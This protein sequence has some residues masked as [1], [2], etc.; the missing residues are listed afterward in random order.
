MTMV[1]SV[2]LGII[3]GL[4]EFLPVSSSG[5]LAAASL[6]MGQTDGGL[7]FDLLLHTGTLA[8][9]FIAYRRECVSLVRSLLTLLKK[10]FSHPLHTVPE[11]DEKF[12]VLVF[13]ATLPLV[14]LKWLGIYDAA[15]RVN[16][17][18]PAI[19]ALLMVNGTVLF[20]ADM[21]SS[22]GKTVADLTLRDA[23][24][25]GLSQCAA[26]LPGLSRSGVTVAAGLLCSLERG[27]AMKFSFIMSLPAVIGACVLKVPELFISGAQTGN[28][29]AY[30]AGAAAAGAVGCASI[31]M[32]KWLS[33]K[34]NF[35]IFSYY[36]LAAGVLIAL[37]GL[38]KQG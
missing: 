36:C 34:N 5:H 1:R 12:L 38:I 32:L 7:A 6:L 30:L 17:C 2:I 18:V 25:I 35:R 31:R 33:D 20:L 23:L 19:G 24:F 3:Q 21:R 10:F 16:G 27:E 4:T 8:A 28:I 9:V 11:G 26:V 15:E 29:G 14:A 13:A 22:G 37:A